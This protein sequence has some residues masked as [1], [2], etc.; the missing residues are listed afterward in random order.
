MLDGRV[1]VEVAVTLAGID[2][3]NTIQISNTSSREEESIGSLETRLITRCD[4][5]SAAC[6]RSG[7]KNRKEKKRTR[8]IIIIA[9]RKRSTGETAIF[10]ARRLTKRND[11]GEEKRQM[12]DEETGKEQVGRLASDVRKELER[13][14][15]QLEILQDD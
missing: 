2:R 11:E 7:K 13:S 4:D 1:H 3:A 14:T 5:L 6:V 12:K 15:H 10:I 9:S 8:R